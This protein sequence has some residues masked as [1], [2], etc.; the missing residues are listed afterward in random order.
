MTRDLSLSSWIERR[1][2]V[3]RHF[4]AA[5][6]LDKKAATISVV[7]PTR[8]VSSTLPLI[9]D[10]LLP[11]RDSGLVDELV[12]VDAASDDG[13]ALTATARG[14]TVLQQDDLMPEFG[15]C[16]GKGD[17][18]WRALSATSGEICVFMD[19]DTENFSD[20]FLL[21]LLGPLIDDSHIRFVKGSFHR[22]LTHLGKSVEKEGGR[23]T[24]LVARPLLSLYM[25]PLAGFAQPLSGEM[26]AHRSVLEALP[27]PVGYGV[28][29]GNLI[30]ASEHVGIDALAQ[31]DLG[32]RQDETK[33]LRDLTPMAYEVLTTVLTRVFGPEGHSPASPAALVVASPDGA[34]TRSVATE[35][36]PPLA[37]VVPDAS[38]G[39][40]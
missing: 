38:A 14:A 9:L 13:T 22:P 21:G 23:V 37:S 17:A 2:Y 30:D 24:E 12:V 6:L 28:E 26:A 39:E 36:R 11:H 15:P 19:S 3:A 25:P 5:R 27:F 31:V 8:N 20:R 33:R 34:E 32:T 40:S 16:L 10:S 4:D 18:M 29:I 7:L 1:S 35:E